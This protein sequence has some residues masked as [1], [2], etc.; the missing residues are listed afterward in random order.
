[1]S[2]ATTCKAKPQTKGN[3]A[4]YAQETN[5]PFRAGPIVRRNGRRAGG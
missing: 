1:M 5:Y 2:K 3:Q 4:N